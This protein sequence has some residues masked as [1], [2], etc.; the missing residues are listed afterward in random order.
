VAATV[1]A[2]E[3]H[4]GYTMLALELGPGEII[5]ARTGRTVEYPIN[6]QVN[7]DLDPAMVRFFHPKTEMAL[8]P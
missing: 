3:L 2:D 1:Y 7:F 8:Q 5:H 4:G 6:S